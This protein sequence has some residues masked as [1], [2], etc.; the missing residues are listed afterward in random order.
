V[1]TTST[2]ET[3]D[4][5]GDPW[6]VDSG[7]TEHIGHQRGEFLSGT[8]KDCSPVT[9]TLADSGGGG[10]N[11]YIGSKSGVVQKMTV[12]RSG[13]NK[14]RFRAMYVPGLSK[15]LLSVPT[16]DR[17]GYGVTIWGGKLG[18]WNSGGGLE[19]TAT[20]SD[21]NLYKLDT[22]ETDQGS[23]SP[24]EARP[25]NFTD[26]YH[27]RWGHA[28]IHRLR[29][30]ASAGRVAGV[31]KASLRDHQSSCEGCARRKARRKPKPKSN[32]AR[33][34]VVGGRVFMDISV[35]NTP[36]VGGRKYYCV[37][38]DDKT[39]ESELVLMRN[40]GGTE[41][42]AAF[43]RYVKKAEMRG[44]KV[45]VVRSDNEG[46]FVS[47]E[48]K[49]LMGKAG[50]VSE[51]TARNSSWQ[52]GPAERRIQTLDRMVGPMMAHAHAPSG[53]WGECVH[54][55]NFTNN[56]LPTTSLKGRSPYEARTG[57][58]PDAS[59][60]RVFGCLAWA[61]VPDTQLRKYVRDKAIKCIFL[62]YGKEAVDGIE[63][64]CYRLWNPRTHRIINAAHRDVIFDETR[65]PWK[66]M[67]E[68]QP[69]RGSGP[70]P[71]LRPPDLHDAVSSGRRSRVGSSSSEKWV[72]RSVRLT[73]PPQRMD[74]S[75]EALQQPPAPVG[76]LSDGESGSSSSS[77]A[78][79]RRS[80]R[81]AGPPE[82][83]VALAMEAER[84]R[85]DRTPLFEE[86][87]E[88][89]EAKEWR[90][91]CEAELSKLRERGFAE[92]CSLPRGRRAIGCKWVLKYRSPAEWATKGV[93]RARLTAKGFS[94]K[95]GIDY[96]ETFAPVVKQKSFR[97][98]MAKAA[99]FGL[100]VRH[101][102]VVSAFTIPDMEDEIYMKQPPRFAVKGS[103]HLV[104]RLKKGLYGTK[105]AS[106]LWY[107]EIN[108]TL[109]SLG[110]KRSGADQCMYV[111]HR[112]K[113]PPVILAAYV[114]DFYLLCGEDALRR[115]IERKLRELYELTD[116]GWLKSSLGMRV[117]RNGNTGAIRLNQ[118]NYIMDLLE[119]FN[120]QD[121]SPV[122]TPSLVGQFLSTD[123]CPQSEVEKEALGDI[124]G[125]YR[126]GCGA[127]MFLATQTRPD[128]AQA[129]H[130][131]CRFM[132]NPGRAHW[133]GVKRVFRY[134]K[135]TADL[136][137]TFKGGQ[138]QGS[139]PACVAYSDADYANDPDN[140][141]SVTGNVVFLFG[142][143]ISW[144][145]KLQRTVALS[146]AEAEY[147]SLAETCKEMIWLRRLLKDL[148]WDQSVPLVWEDNQSTIAMSKND[149]YHHRTKHI[150]VRYHFTR[151]CVENG[152]IQLRHCKTEHMVADILT[153]PLPR[154]RFE[155]L[156]SQLMGC[157]PNG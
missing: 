98:L 114:D 29:R 59:K 13:V 35:V 34:G 71:W 23:A 89:D 124:P 69:A 58:L 128:I 39:R 77:D 56:R 130:R 129:T 104:L 68:S 119:E 136:G 107:R 149:V 105:Q 48:M 30:A 14:L 88:G 11:S 51:A 43:T 78:W 146:T 6:I 70:D 66:E 154:Q 8:L 20:L 134:L 121:C 15:N 85:F 57:K 73:G 153:K 24:V 4:S 45:Q 49:D 80:S 110:F 81:P 131:L 10:A 76:V 125:R 113:G 127:L 42:E 109:T 151:E 47:V 97:V 147:M 91:A 116:M 140:R 122:A 62:G 157:D 95:K 32:S 117:T 40:R 3:K 9:Y 103:E 72:R 65:F 96:Q 142:G 12:L 123:M 101:Y 41:A 18:I 50:T 99:H 115:Q 135:G 61:I 87:M 137:I 138:G 82:R 67:A 83:L 145:S 132:S 16:L 75:A 112:D 86:A 120:M 1:L 156:R 118:A 74:T 26:V 126:Q 44:T 152:D 133:N 54:N 111:L 144:S 36:T 84:N 155:K 37:F 94:Q 25:S 100:P 46:A 108:K 148:E 106:R 63:R 5:K 33:S 55:A 139:G 52:N 92:L 60:L 27:Q 21:D 150:D 102:D 2:G 38:V 22:G 64:D 17:D 7:C 53:F 143:P 79:V 141:R 90:S 93:R 28:D 31:K 19:A